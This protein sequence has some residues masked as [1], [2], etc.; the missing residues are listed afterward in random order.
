MA[1]MLARLALTDYFV[2]VLLMHLVTVAETVQVCSS[3]VPDKAAVSVCNPVV[4]SG[5][6]VIGAV[7]NPVVALGVDFVQV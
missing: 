4:A 2:A 7:C 3:E 1:V 5:V 6:V